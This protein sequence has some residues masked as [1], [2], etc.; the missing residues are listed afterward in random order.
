LYLP[1]ILGRT[2][3]LSLDLGGLLR[4]T[5]LAL[6]AL[7]V[8][9]ASGAAG[10][11]AGSTPGDS[12][13]EPVCLGQYE[14]V[15]GQGRSCRVEGG[16]WKVT[17][18]DGGYLLT[19]GP[20]PFPVGHAHDGT[21]HINTPAAPRPPLC[22]DFN[23]H[24]NYTQVALLTWPSDLNPNKTVAQVRSDIQTM[25]GHLYN[26]AVLSG[27][28]RGADYVFD[29]DQ[30]G[31]IRVDQVEL[32]TPSG[33]ASFVTIANDL[34]ARGYNKSNEKYVIHYDG[35]MQYCGQ[36]DIRRSEVD[37]V[38]NP[39]N[40]GPNYGINYDCLGWFVLMHENGHNLGAVQ[41]N[42]PFSTG[43]GFHCWQADDV[44][45][46]SDGGDKDPGFLQYDCLD[47]D[48]W[49]CRN[50][51]Y[52]DAKIGAGEGGGPGSYIDTNWNIGECYVRWIVNYACVKATR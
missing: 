7:L 49:D 47:F 21:Y 30:T 5:T 39:N 10:H 16:L 19:H 48:H 3:R 31:A 17:L 22:S 13:P 51:D 14:E 11:S 24:G 23:P 34:R 9:P 27:S 28:P 40:I 52:Y 1:S 18:A 15:V 50:N 33:S 25:N 12:R 38:S 43:T 4:W 42:A 35:P 32:P 37:G 26:Q 8:M 41:Y 36:G 44:M 29:C 2:R 6:A 45:C 20:D 46:Y